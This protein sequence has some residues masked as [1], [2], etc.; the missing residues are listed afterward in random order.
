MAQLRLLRCDSAFV[1]R[2]WNFS[3]DAVAARLVLAP[4][5]RRGASFLFSKFTHLVLLMSTQAQ[6]GAR[7]PR[8][9]QDEPGLAILREVNQRVRLVYFA[10]GLQTG[11]TSQAAG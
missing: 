8:A 11:G 9:W 2:L 4:R 1:T 6:V 10:S 3:D 7:F 5:I